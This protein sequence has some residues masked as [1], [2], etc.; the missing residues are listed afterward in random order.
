MKHLIRWPLFWVFVCYIIGAFA[1]I[2]FGTYL[3][4]GHKAAL[5]LFGLFAG[6]WVLNRLTVK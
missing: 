5:T 2:Y 3:A 1:L 4:A 6:S